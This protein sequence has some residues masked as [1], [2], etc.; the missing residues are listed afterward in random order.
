MFYRILRFIN[1]WYALTA[2]WMFLAA[3][4]VALSFMFLF[5]QVTLGLFFVGLG[6]LGVTVVTSGFLQSV[7][8]RLARRKLGTG[9]CPR[10][11]ASV[12]SASLPDAALQCLVCGTLYTANGSEIERSPVMPIQNA[13]D[14][15]IV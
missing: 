15:Q 6:A 8:R 1:A 14:D 3:F 10:C 11:S 13:G 9:M 12:V 2:L 7:Q 4:V 5:P